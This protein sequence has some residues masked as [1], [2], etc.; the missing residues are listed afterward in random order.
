MVDDVLAWLF[1]T[2][3]G[4]MTFLGGVAVI[5]ITIRWVGQGGRHRG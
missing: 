2:P 3:E 5:G 1:G 4:V